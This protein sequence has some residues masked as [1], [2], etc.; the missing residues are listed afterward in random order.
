MRDGQ[1][2]E[3]QCLRQGNRIWIVSSDLGDLLCVPAAKSQQRLQ[4]LPAQVDF[5]SPEGD[6]ANV[7][8]VRFAPL[9]GNYRF[10]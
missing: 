10:V 2:A 5:Q 9:R 6:F 4:N 8:A 7:G 1:R 3:S